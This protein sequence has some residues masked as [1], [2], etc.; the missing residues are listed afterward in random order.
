MFTFFKVDKYYW[1]KLSASWNQD[2]VALSWNSVLF[3]HH[4][5]QHDQSQEG[6]HL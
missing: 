3:L 4:C 6:G 5:M 1:I 2:K